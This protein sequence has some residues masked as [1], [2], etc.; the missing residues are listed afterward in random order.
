MAETDDIA[1]TVQFPA[2][3]ALVSAPRSTL[4]ATL[5]A[6]APFRLR[7]VRALDAARGLDYSL[8][9]IGLMTSPPKFLVSIFED[10]ALMST[11]T[12]L[13]ARGDLPWAVAPAVPL[14]IAGLGLYVMRFATAFVVAAAS[15][16]LVERSALTPKEPFAV[17]T[18]LKRAEVSSM[19]RSKPGIAVLLVLS[20]LFIAGDADVYEK[21]PNSS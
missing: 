8:V 11:G 15:F 3:P 5:G 16:L 21:S 19:I 13:V 6:A 4:D 2:A 12:L 10:A 9:I 14:G 17:D 20:I 18:A 1:T 7:H